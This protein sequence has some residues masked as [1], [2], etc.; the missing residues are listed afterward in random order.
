MT[1]AGGNANTQD[2]IASEAPKLLTPAQKFQ[3]IRQLKADL[4]HIPPISGF[5]GDTITDQTIGFPD[6]PLFGFFSK[7]NEAIA[8]DCHCTKRTVIR[9]LQ[10]MKKRGHIGIKRRWDD[11]S[12]IWPI[13]KSEVTE[14]SPAKGQKCHQPSDKNV[15]LSPLKTPLKSPLKESIAPE[16]FNS[17]W[18][19]YPRKTDKA[20]ASK[21]YR[22]AL[23]KATAETILAGVQRYALEKAGTEPRFIKYPASWLNGECWNNAA[24]PQ[25]RRQAS[26]LAA[27]A[28]GIMKSIESGDSSDEF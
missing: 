1:I 2:A 16:G 28:R 12:L 22:T 5:I 15:T 11:T 13:L 6:H 19:A 27:V 14:T 7:G 10:A 4:E 21:A 24:E 18:L 3:F 25:S 26:G 9:A 23:T 20:K 17:F 8:A